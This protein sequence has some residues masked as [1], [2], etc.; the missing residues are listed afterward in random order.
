MRIVEAN[1]R[2]SPQRTSTA[3]TPNIAQRTAAP[4]R[5]RRARTDPVSRAASRGSYLASCHSR[6][7][8]R[9]R[10]QSVNSVTEITSTPRSRNVVVDNDPAPPTSRVVGLL[11]H[12][13]SRN[14]DRPRDSPNPR[15]AQSSVGVHRLRTSG[16]GAVAE[17]HRHEDPGTPGTPTPALSSTPSKTR[18]VAL[19]MHRHRRGKRTIGSRWPQLPGSVR[20]LTVVVPGV[21]VQNVPEVAFAG[22]SS[23][24]A[25]T[26]VSPGSVPPTR[27]H[28]PLF[29]KAPRKQF[30][31]HRA[32]RNT[33]R[34]SGRPRLDK[35]RC[36]TSG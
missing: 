34:S 26:P 19:P 32:F 22:F 14:V 11:G 36:A 7:S 12:L 15:S 27:S 30:V 17:C 10:S 29:L 3:P 21:L 23:C 9:R 18:R 31:T 4:V 25:G 5:A 2:M 35:P 1:P 20:A 33:N 6:A 24:V 13:R 8:R 16:Q 28:T